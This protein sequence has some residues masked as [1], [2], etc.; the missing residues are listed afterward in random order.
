M[1]AIKLQLGSKTPQQS[2]SRLTTP[3]LRKIN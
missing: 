3:V 1:T 2:V